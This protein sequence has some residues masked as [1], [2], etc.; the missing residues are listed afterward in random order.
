MKKWQ[1]ALRYL[2]L[3]FVRLRATPA[4]IS[5]G[6]AVGIFWGMFPLP[7]FQMATAV[8]TAAVLRGN[9]LAAALATWIG[10]PLTTVPITA[11]NFHLGQMALG[12]DWSDLPPLKFDSLD[13]ALE[14]G[15]EVLGVFLLG[16]FLSGLLFGVLSYFLGIP[17]V[18][19][20]QRRV[21]ERR[22]KRQKRFYRPPAMHDSSRFN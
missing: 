3:R 9:K 13:A 1:R 4:E 8:V 21:A 2:Y 15:S 16:C 10:N 7:G 14:V 5:R 18:R 19:A 20:L 6:F 12:R 11:F 17:I 22:L